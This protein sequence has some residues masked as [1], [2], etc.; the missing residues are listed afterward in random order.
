M[1]WAYRLFI[2][3]LLIGNTIATSIVLGL[4]LVYIIGLDRKRRR[5]RLLSTLLTLF[6]LLHLFSR[7][8][9]YLKMYLNNAT[10]IALTL[11]WVVK[12]TPELD[13][14]SINLKLQSGLEGTWK[15]FS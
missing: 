9:L 4:G 10:E 8:I 1:Y 2:M 15:G 14:T 6:W 5:K 13:T 11:F 7:L 3:T 12:W